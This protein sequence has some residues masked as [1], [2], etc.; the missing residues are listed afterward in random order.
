MNS[1]PNCLRQDPHPQT[2]RHRLP[3]G[4]TDCHCH[5][6]EDPAQYPLNDNRSYTPGLATIEQYEQMCAT[7]G[8]E[9]TVQVNASI[10][11]FD[12]R[13]TLDAIRKLGQHRA[14]GV[15]GIA[16]QGSQAELEALHEGGIR[17]V[18]VSTSVKGYGGTDAIGVLAARVKPMNWHIQVHLRSANELPALEETLL[19]TPVPLVIDHLG[20]IKGDEGIG[21][22]GFK[23]LV[24]LLRQ[25]DDVWCKLSSWYRRSKSGAPDFTDMIEPMRALI[26]ARPDRLVFG[27]NW[28]HPDLFPPSVVPNDGALVDQFC[29]WVPEEDLRQR[30]LVSNPATLYGFEQGSR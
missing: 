20:G 25:R 13:P 24:R 10:Y 11:G 4:A 18:R 23:T 16:P 28:P 8:L 5:V 30:I 3:A 19:N 15:A 2:P 1:I 12:N 29:D 27:T 22:P 26:D 7:V 14:R 17:G 6:F 9:R 21:H